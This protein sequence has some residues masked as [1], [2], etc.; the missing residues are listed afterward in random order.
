MGGR[1]IGREREGEKEREGGKEGRREEE[2][3]EGIYLSLIFSVI[4]SSKTTS[5]HNRRA[6]QVTMYNVYFC[7]IPFSMMY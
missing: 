6:I 1:E 4:G 7:T 5:G 3:K 2:K